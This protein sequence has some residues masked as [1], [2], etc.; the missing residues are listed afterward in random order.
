MVVLERCT[1]QNSGWSEVS[2]RDC[3]TLKCHEM[4]VRSRKSSEFL[5]YRVGVAQLVKCSAV[6]CGASGV[7]VRDKGC[8]ATLSKGSVSEA[9]WYE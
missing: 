5:I 3:G 2:A 4:S 7:T 9:K 8:R 6:K 1:L